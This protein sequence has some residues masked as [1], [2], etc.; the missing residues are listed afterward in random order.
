MNTNK[1]NKIEKLKSMYFYNSYLRVFT[2]EEMII[3]DEIIKKLNMVMRIDELDI[4]KMGYINTEYNKLYN[5]V[6]RNGR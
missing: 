2:D 5:I 1:I 3:C 6:Y 4:S